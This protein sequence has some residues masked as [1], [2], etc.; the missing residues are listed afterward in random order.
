[1]VGIDGIG[2]SAA[3]NPVRVVGS[4]VGVVEQAAQ[5]IAAARTVRKRMRMEYPPMTVRRGNK[6]RPPSP[7]LKHFVHKSQYRGQINAMSLPSR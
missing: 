2:G 6:L 3:I 7:K 4:G 1:M 5:D